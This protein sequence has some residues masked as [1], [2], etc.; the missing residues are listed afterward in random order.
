MNVKCAAILQN[1][2]SGAE[3]SLESWWVGGW[4]WWW[5]GVLCV[6]VC[7]VLNHAVC[8]G[9]RGAGYQYFLRGGKEPNVSAAENSLQTTL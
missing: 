1:L 7:V 5:W 3:G 8:A 2:G 9:C 6:C 4:E